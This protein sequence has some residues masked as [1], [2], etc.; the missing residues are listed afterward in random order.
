MDDRGS[1]VGNGKSIKL[2]TSITLFSATAL[3]LSNTGGG[4]IFIASTS[5]LIYGGSPGV[6]LIFWLVGGLLNFG[7][8]FCYI[9]VA[10]LLPKSGGAYYYVKEVFG[11]FPAFVLLWGFVLTICA[12]AWALSCYT[13][14]L[15]VITML[16]PECPP[17]DVA[18]KVLAA[19]FMVTMIV[20]NCLY[21]KYVIR[22]QALLS[23]GK[24]I[25]MLI[26]I[27][28]CFTA[29]GSSSSVD[30]INAMFRGSTTDPGNIALG[31]ASGYFAFGGWQMI[32]IIIE[33]VEN[34]LV[35]VPRAL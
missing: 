3:L 11:A 13:A 18:T 8:A 7:L 22:V 2:Q 10:L 12:P 5:M 21:M 16:F 4:S 27:A 15:Y 30:N 23:A 17:P 1:K 6:A 29:I 31:L 9:E 33:E 34:P 24:M 32:T 19:W 20:L 35:N 28:A 26:I 14:A 25:A